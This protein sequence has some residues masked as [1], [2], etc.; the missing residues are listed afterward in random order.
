MKYLKIQNN[1]VLDIRL[2]ALM[3]GTTKAN[4]R[5][6]IGQFGTGL[7]YTLAFLFRNNL[8]FR[9]FTGEEEVTIYTEVENIRGEDFEII[10]INGQR[11]SITT[12]MGEDWEAWMIVRELWCNALDEGGATKEVTNTIGGAKDA[13]TFFIQ[14]DSQI[15]KVLDS[16]H[17][18][19]IHDQHA[20][21]DNHECALYPSGD[22]FCIYK[23]GVLIYE[24]KDAKSVFS[25]DYKSA[26][27]NE[28]REFKGSPS[29]VV[30]NCLAGANEAA[31]RYFLENITEKHYEGDSTMDYNWYRSFGPTW[32]KV[33]GN[34]KVIHQK[35]LDEIKARGSKPDEGSLLIV[36]ERLYKFLTKQ[37]EGVGALQVASKIGD[38]YEDYNEV[39]EGK[40]KQGLAILEACEY[41]M[42]P[43]LEYV[44]GFFED[45][46]CLAKVDL[47]SK[48]VFI[49]QAFMQKPL[50]AVVA[51][52]IEENEHFNTGYEDH[53]REFQQH[54][55]D[56][57]TRELL[58]RNEVEV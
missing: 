19:F 26:D 4:D 25:Y 9:I 42:H 52:L 17:K 21:F 32:K 56:L 27:I 16:W 43:E 12:R 28:L 31:V 30:V 47:H 54:F 20:I 11:T 50:S 29:H 22:K 39:V 5:Y 44:Y 35:V 13:T 2:V 6:K 45:R 55:I 33:I 7:K 10:C 53:T 46:T 1:G 14:A 38:F 57:Y 15:Q 58:K 8:S 41:P 24:H 51:M 18:Y 48:K 49:S 23:Q 3:G 36:P 37:F 40:I 34:A